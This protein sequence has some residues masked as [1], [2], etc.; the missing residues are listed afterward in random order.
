MDSN[1][2][3]NI[4][5]NIS[6]IN[7]HYF[8]LPNEWVLYQ[9]VWPSLLLFGI[10]SDFSFIWTILR[11][12]S[13][14]T[15]TFIYLINLSCADLILLLTYIVPIIIRFQYSPIRYEGGLIQYT[16]FGVMRLCLYFASNFL[17]CLVT[18]ERFFAICYPLKHRMLKGS[19]NTIKVIV[20]SWMAGVAVGCTVIPFYMRNETKK[21]CIC[22]QTTSLL[23]T[24]QC[25]EIAFLILREL[26]G[27]Y[28]KT[29]A[30][31]Y[32]LLWLYLLLTNVFM[33]T[34][35]MQTL[36]RRQRNKDLTTISNTREEQFRQVA[37]MLIANGSV[38]LFC[39]SVNFI[40]QA[41]YS[42]QLFG[43]DYFSDY[44]WHVWAGFQE[45]VTGFNASINPLVYTVTNRRYR[46][47]T[48]EAIGALPC[49][50]MCHIKRSHSKTERK[51]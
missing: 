6:T 14:Q 20:F 51:M 47:A 40:G 28:F 24:I 45:L 29:C 32:F 4:T 36:N 43:H 17:V 2:V 46:K 50:V 16:I 15:T 18:A 41:L 1:C 19:T 49:F 12:P 23:D 8:Y 31:F 44:Q 25:D 9:I 33:Y 38:F 10:F 30:M 37:I 11:T 13:L 42:L 3:S 22:R 5:H 27:V 35:I 21:E 26:K 7:V 34:R 48:K 39:S